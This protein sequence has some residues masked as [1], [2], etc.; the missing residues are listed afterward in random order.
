MGRDFDFLEA[1][2]VGDVL[3]F[4][5]FYVNKKIRPL[6]RFDERDFERVFTD[7][8]CCLLLLYIFISAYAVDQTLTLR[9]QTDTVLSIIQH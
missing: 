1:A 8:Y 5:K 6:T 2:R 3:Y 4:E 7:F 9:I